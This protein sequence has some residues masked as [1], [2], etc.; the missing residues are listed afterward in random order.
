MKILKNYKPNGNH[1]I[2]NHKNPNSQIQ[3]QF[4]ISKANQ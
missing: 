3:F 1:N 2:Y 4:K